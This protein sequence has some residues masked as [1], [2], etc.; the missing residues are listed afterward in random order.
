M[1]EQGNGTGDPFDAFEQ[2][3]QER[4]RAEVSSPPVPSGT[5]TSVPRTEVAAKNTFFHHLEI[6]WTCDVFAGVAVQACTAIRKQP[7]QQTGA[8]FKIHSYIWVQI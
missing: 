8:F 7:I 5:P 1:A 6:E 2:E 4:G 3:L